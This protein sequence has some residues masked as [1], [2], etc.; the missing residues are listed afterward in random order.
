VTKRS[1]LP[2]GAPASLSIRVVCLKGEVM[3]S[4]RSFVRPL[5]SL[6]LAAA[7]GL[8]LGAPAL[9]QSQGG[10]P[11]ILFIL[12]DNTGFG[13][14]GVY[15][16]GE[17][18]GAPTPRIDRLASEGIML[19]QFLVEPG[20]TP[21]RAALMTGRYSIRSGLSLVTVE[22]S[23]LSLPQSE[24]TIAEMLH[25]VG[26]ATAMH[27]KWH[28]GSETCSQPQN[29]GFDKF[30]GIPPEVTW[31]AFLMVRQG[32]MTRS[33]SVPPDKGPQIVEAKRGEPLKVVKPYTE[34]VRRNIDW[35]LAD[36]GTDFMQRQ[37]A[38]GKPFFLYL[39]I[40]R[41]HFPN[42]PSKRFVG[43]SRIGNYGDSLMEGDA[44]VGTM[45]D[46]LKNL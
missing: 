22:G 37:K 11:N 8:A 26:Y 16:G 43:T 28:L 32:R 20:C 7:A 31:D 36:R 2:D 3:K 14:I 30:Y 34:E 27:G 38:A 21:S 44:V 35:E 33:L 5:F 45:L 17:Y 9:A 1:I 25:D 41:T 10:K 12:N 15:G 46:A 39:P 40:S 19:R 6:L 23:S 24:I 42:L 13:D 4:L 18:R 29:K